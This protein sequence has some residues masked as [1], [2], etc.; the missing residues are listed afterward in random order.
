MTKKE[1]D[2]LVESITRNCYGAAYS[3]EQ[4]IVR[5]VL[6]TLKSKGKLTTDEQ[7]F[8]KKRVDALIA[9]LM[10]QAEGMPVPW[11]NQVKEAIARFLKKS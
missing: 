8:Q 10:Y 5:M 7:S 11:N 3:H 1:F 6:N 4:S 9:E 2:Q